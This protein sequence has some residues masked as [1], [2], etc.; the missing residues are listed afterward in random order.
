MLEYLR[1]GLAVLTVFVAT[2][3]DAQVVIDDFTSATPQTAQPN[4]ESPASVI[5]GFRDVKSNN[6]GNTAAVD[7]GTLRCS[8]TANFQGCTVQYD[9]EDLDPD[10]LTV[11]G[12]APVDLTGGGVFDHIAIDTF[13][14]AGACNLFIQLCD[15]DL[16]TPQCESA[17]VSSIS[18]GGTETFSFGDF[19]PGLDL[20]AVTAVLINLTPTS[21]AVDCSIGALASTPVEL[22]RFE[23][24]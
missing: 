12:F 7:G 1:T 19:D 8:G 15:N 21:V 23:I 2:V 18:D 4:N 3:A 14:A 6:A 9:G 11:P 20:T 17:S 10:N 16:P 22:L 13:V 24:D 5:G